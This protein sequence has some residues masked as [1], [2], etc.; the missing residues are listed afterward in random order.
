MYIYMYKRTVLSRSLG[1][2]F[3]MLNTDFP[4]GLIQFS[5]Y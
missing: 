1:N 5:R 3:I 4:F 2:V